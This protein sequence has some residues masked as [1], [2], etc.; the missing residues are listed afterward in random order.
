MKIKV[1]KGDIYLANLNGGV[2]SEQTGIRPVIIL[3]NERVSSTCIV[4][5][6]TKVDKN[7][8]FKSH[9]IIYKLD[10]LL[11]DSYALLK[12]VRVIDKKRLSKYIGKLTNCEIKKIIDKIKKNL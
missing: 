5:P 12:Q 9:I 3:Y 11:Y 6:L 1:N 8:E 10:R 2:G 4:I 7:K